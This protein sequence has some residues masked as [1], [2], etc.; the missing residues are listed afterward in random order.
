MGG[1]W[2]LSDAWVFAAIEGTGVEDGYTLTQVVAKGDGI[3]HAIL[4]EEE[5]CRAVPRL[6]AAGLIG[7]ELGADRYWHTEKGSELYARCM[8]RRGL[9]GWIDA[10]PPALR[11]LGSPFDGPWNLPPG[12]F[13]NAVREWHRQALQIRARLDRGRRR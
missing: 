3:N 11:R 6:A 10:I 4:T 13:D 9:F 12:A 5:F 8:R 2:Q 1:Q 7:A